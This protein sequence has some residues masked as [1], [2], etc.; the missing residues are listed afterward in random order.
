M[1][2]WVAAITG[3][4]DQIDEMGKILAEG[5][6]LELEKRD[7]FEGMLWLTDDT[8]GK[9]ILI[10]LWASEEARKTPWPQPMG[11]PVSTQVGVE[12]ELLGSFEV[13]IERFPSN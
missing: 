8:R 9:A 6:L 3:T 7:G 13:A 2:A 10:G 4:A 11:T 5:T 12:R 1:I